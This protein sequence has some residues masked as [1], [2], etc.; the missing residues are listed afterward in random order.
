M[1]RQ[2]GGAEMRFKV[3]S[4]E[5]GVCRAF[6]KGLKLTQNAFEMEMNLKKFCKIKF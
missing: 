3:Q 4:N 5:H 6:I 2:K 1:R